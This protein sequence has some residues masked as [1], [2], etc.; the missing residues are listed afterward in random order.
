MTLNEIT[1]RILDNKN[2]LKVF[3]LRATTNELSQMTSPCYYP[4]IHRYYYELLNLCKLSEKELKTFIKETYFP[5]K[6]KDFL[7]VND[8]YTNLILIATNFFLNQKD[9]ISAHTCLIF[10]NLK[11]Y[12]STMSIN[13]K[14]CN[15]N[16]FLAALERIP[17]THLYR[18][19]KTIGNCLMYLSRQ[20]MLRYKKEIQEW[21]IESLIAMI[22]ETRHR[23]SQ[24]T[25]SFAKS[26]YH[27]SKEKGGF[28]TTSE[29]EEEGQFGKISLEKGKKLID[30]IV[31]DI[32][33]Y[34]L[35][36]KKALTDAKTITKV[37]IETAINITKS[38]NN[39]KF[40]EN[41]KVCLDL[42]IRDLSKI[43]DLCKD[44]YFKYVRNLMSLKRTKKEIYFKQQIY[45]LTEELVKSFDFYTSYK[46]L[47]SQSIF[48]INLFVALYLTMILRNKIC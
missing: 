15:P 25:K 36:D 28:L 48:M 44:G 8:P 33:V 5:T 11:F 42:F 1:N 31:T 14:Y 39:V 10:L 21:N 19:E 3:L 41:I 18:R 46:N 40:S 34:R 22:Q 20:I 29:D 17:K 47:T 13:I 7:L 30:D 26:Y 32:T 43:S 12:T 2:T 45:L 9:L 4:K 38:L 37:N 24:S 23:I 35:I 6:A 16:V 27:I